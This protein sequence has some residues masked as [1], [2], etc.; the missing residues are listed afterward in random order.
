MRLV[1]TVDSIEAVAEIE[2]SR[3]ER[4][5]GTAR[6]VARKLGAP[7]QHLFRRPPIRPFLHRADRLYARP[8]EAVAADADAVPRRH[9]A[10]LDEEKKPLRAVDNDRARRFPAMICDALPLETRVEGVLRARSDVRPILAGLDVRPGP[11]DFIL[12]TKIV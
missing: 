4:I 11:I 7:A 1:R 12:R 8:A 3:T 9:P 10:F 6:H 2:G 5:V